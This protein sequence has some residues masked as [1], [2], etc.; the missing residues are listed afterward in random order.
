MWYIQVH[1]GDILGKYY[2][3]KFTPRNPKKYKGNPTTIWYRS[4]WE[5]KAMLY[6]DKNPGILEWSSEELAIPYK[7]PIDGRIHRYFPD[8][9]VKTSQGDTI[10]IEIKPKAQVNK[11]KQRKRKTKKFLMEI[12]EWEKNKAKWA[13]AQEY[14]TDHKWKFLILTE[15]ELGIHS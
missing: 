13:S 3:G 15:K 11:P 1:F 7:S 6:F 8:F 9:K 5:L 4:S 14:A 2:Q 10:L 12:V